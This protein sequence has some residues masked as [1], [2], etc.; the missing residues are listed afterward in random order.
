M[1][2]HLSNVKAFLPL[3]FA[4]DRINYAR[5]ASVYYSDMCPLE[6]THPEAYNAFHQGDFF[7]Q[8]SEGC[9]FAQVAVDQ[10][11]KQTVNRDSKT[12][13]G[14]ISFSTKQKTGCN[15]AMGINSA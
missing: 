6:A 15:T 2:L 10:T 7:V 11:I 4:Y 3:F 12:A 14:I 9:H 8:R 13:G 1:D 5:Y